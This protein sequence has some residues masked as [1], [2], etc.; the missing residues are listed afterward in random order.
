ME[1]LQ[2]LL[3]VF[4]LNQSL[5]TKLGRLNSLVINQ[6]IV[7]SSNN[8]LALQKRQIVEPPN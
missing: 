7:H 5:I 2:V 6:V 3:F 8:P 4:P 1:H